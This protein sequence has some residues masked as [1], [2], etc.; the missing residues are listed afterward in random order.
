[1]VGLT[2]TSISNFNHGITS[3]AGS[4]GIWPLA[5]LWM[6]H[7]LYADIWVADK[8]WSAPTAGKTLREMVIATKIELKL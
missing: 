2:P 5:S 3:T 1:M 4:S 6:I 7:E 8:S